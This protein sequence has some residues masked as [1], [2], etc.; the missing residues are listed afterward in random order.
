LRLLITNFEDVD[1]LRFLVRITDGDDIDL[2]T[3]TDGLPAFYSS[4]IDVV[5]PGD[6]TTITKIELFPVIELNGEEIRSIEPAYTGIFEAGDIIA[7][8]CVETDCHDTVDN[9]GNNLTDCADP[10]CQFVGTEVNCYDGVDDDCDGDIDC[11]DSECIDPDSDINTVLMYRFNEGSGNFTCDNSGNGHNVIFGDGS[12]TPGVEPCPAWVSNAGGYRIDFINDLHTYYLNVSNDEGW[13]TELSEMTIEVQ[14]N[15][16]SPGGSTGAILDKSDPGNFEGFILHAGHCN[17]PYTVACWVIQLGNGTEFKYHRC[18]M[19]TSYW[20]QGVFN[21]SL[22][23]DSSLASDHLKMYDQDG[24]LC[25]SGSTFNGFGSIKIPDVDM[26]IGLGYY[27][28]ALD[29]DGLMDNI[30]ISN[31][32]RTI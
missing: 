25:G 12:C 32:A 26:I 7:V 5:Y 9:D 8:G 31:I 30:I 28:P 29:W 4:W 1:I 20:Y 16:T 23:Y 21:F 11:D 18:S 6:V 24:L 15:Y 13:E 14:I 19:P 2:I 22:V 10:Y 3:T 17:P 27:S